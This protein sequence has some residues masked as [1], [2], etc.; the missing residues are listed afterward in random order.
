MSGNIRS[1]FLSFTIISVL[2]FSA[3]GTTTVYAGGG[4]GGHSDG[5]STDSEPGRRPKKHAVLE[6]LPSNTTVAVLNAH[7]KAQ[8]LATQESAY[9][10]ALTSDPIWCPAGQSP[11]P[12]ANGCT[13]TFSSFAALLAELA[14]NPAYQ[15]AGIIYIQQGAYN[16]GESIIDFSSFNLSNISNFDLTLQGGWNTITNTVDPASSSNFN[17]PMIIGSSANPWGGSLS[18]NNINISDT[19][20]TGLT[21]YAQGDVNINLSKFERNRDAG[22]IINAG[23]NVSIANSS[24]SNPGTNRLQ[25]TGL[26]I[27][28]GGSV[29]LFDVLAN[30]N[31][32]VGAN[33]VADG[34]VAINSSFVGGSS[35]SG[36]KSTTTTSCPGSNSQ[37]CG[38]G[39]WIVTPDA[40]DLNG[41]VANDNFLWG[42]KLDAGLDVN[43]KDS[44]FNANS[45]QVPTFIDDT[46][47]FITSGANVSLN[48]VQANNNRLYG[49]QIDAVGDV[50]I[51]NSTFSNNAGITVANGVSTFYGDGLWVVSGG[52]ID[53]NAVTAS[54]NGLSGAH[55]EAANGDVIITNSFFN[56][57]TTGSATDLLGKG[58]VVIGQNVFI[59]TVTLDGNQLFGASIQA[60]GD[61][62]LD[63][64]TATN[65]GTD[66]VIVD[67]ACTTLNS[68][69]F[70][71]NGQYGLN[72]VNPAL[73]I[74]VAPTFGG[75]GAGDIFPASPAACPVLG[76]GGGGGGGNPGG[77]NT[78]NGNGTN[79]SNESQNNALSTSS[80][81][82]MGKSLGSTAAG[83]LSLNNLFAGT[84]QILGVSASPSGSVT[85]LSIFTGKYAYVHSSNGL[86]IVSLII[87]SLA[88]AAKIE[89]L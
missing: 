45:T 14:G 50:F 40:I 79:T 77:G 36:T 72:L 81:V 64:V 6:N 84:Y 11:T 76:G 46:G 27:T 26:D 58:I 78:G 41:V 86:Q 43:V 3:I 15:G 65:N 21:V 4:R 32:E 30:G 12:G 8:P 83:T 57:N 9:A 2:L 24:F 25:R 67:A 22:A 85:R 70:T 59:D 55:L 87:A 74:T 51:N 88:E 48:N 1:F 18:I 19:N 54:N 47:I 7:G 37:F 52:T 60:T 34:R 80:I 10:I 42:A 5:K 63:F 33:I 75:N 31:R 69:A 17:V 29:S 20:N 16:G 82:L 28:S 53:L 13:P 66:G 56:N 23:G 68:G 61:V 71:G 35:F 39:L 49:A 89:G 62:F 44:I 73:N 38:F